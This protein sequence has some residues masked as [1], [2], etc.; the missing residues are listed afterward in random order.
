MENLSQP[1]AIPTLVDNY[2]WSW[3]LIDGS[4]VIVDPGASEPIL[5][6]LGKIS[7]ILL[8][9]HHLD[10]TA[11]VDAIKLAHPAVTV[12][13][14][15]GA[16]PAIDKIVT[17][18]DSILNLQVIATPGHTLDHIIYV[19]DRYV[20]VGDHLFKYG[21][22]RVFE[23]SLEVM[24]ASLQKIKAL[25]AD[26]LC[27]PAHEYTVDNLLFTKKYLPFPGIEQEIENNRKLMVTLPMELS[28][29]LKNNPFLACE[30]LAEFVRLRKAKDSFKV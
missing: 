26:L 30:S 5:T 16:H 7:Y 2:V 15:K 19:G 29:Q 28:E 8:T 24:Y 17:E 27:F 21:C 10:H 18:G 1:I 23:A 4:W 6:K 14:P 20:F 13:G 12:V 3:Q 9:H 22:G 11:G 25:S